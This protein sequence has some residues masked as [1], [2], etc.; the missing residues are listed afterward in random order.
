MALRTLFSLALAFMLHL[1]HAGEPTHAVSP[2]STT[3]AAEARWLAILDAA[4][5]LPEAARVGQVNAAFNTFGYRSDR[6][7][8]GIDDYWDAPLEF[9]AR[10]F[11][12]CEDYAIA[13]YFMLVRSGVPRERL[14]LAF[15]FHDREDAADGLRSPAGGARTH[16][17]L[18]YQP[19]GQT[20][21]L[22]LDMINETA[23]LAARTDLRLVFDFDDQ[24]TYAIHMASVSTNA[25]QRMMLRWLDALQRVG[26]P[27]GGSLRIAARR[28]GGNA[29]VTTAALSPRR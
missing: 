10:G 2:S 12:D 14:K 23:P 20:Q 1:A 15:A 4:L 5:Q 16:V 9:V 27:D 22:V 24:A 18:L 6:E 21:P 11:G 19:D 8:H 7:V 29:G 25:V 26:V 13:K 17:V 28:P 3:A